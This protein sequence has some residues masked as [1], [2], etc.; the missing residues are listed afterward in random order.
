MLPHRVAPWITP[1]LGYNVKYCTCAAKLII[2]FIVF[3][4]IGHITFCMRADDS[5]Y[6][7]SAQFCLL[8]S[9]PGI[10]ATQVVIQ[11]GKEDG[12]GMVV[13]ETENIQ[14]GTVQRLPCPLTYLQRI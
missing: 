12:Q 2:L 7:K 4:T 1:L 5:G 13:V 10:F 6:G 11:C 9:V 14:T 8:V 3:G